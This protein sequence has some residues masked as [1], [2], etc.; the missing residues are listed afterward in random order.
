MKK[1]LVIGNFSTSGN[2]NSFLT[3]DGSEPTFKTTSFSEMACKRKPKKRSDL[4]HE[5]PIVGDLSGSFQPRL[6]KLQYDPR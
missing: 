6:C 1:K 2:G 3:G 4:R 5:Q